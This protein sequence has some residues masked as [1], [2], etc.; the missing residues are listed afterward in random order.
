MRSLGFVLVPDTQLVKFGTPYSAGQGR[1]F[2]L[3][4]TTPELV[5]MRAP[6]VS[7]QVP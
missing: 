1:P 6:L 7:Y 3:L 2:M 5:P 4:S